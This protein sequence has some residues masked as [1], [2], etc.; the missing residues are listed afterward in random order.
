[1]VPYK[2]DKLSTT[3]I[4]TAQTSLTKA[5]PSSSSSLSS[6]TT[7]RPHLYQ[8]KTAP[9][10]SRLAPEDALTLSQ[11]RL[12][13]RGVEE[14]HRPVTANGSSI[15]NTGGLAARVTAATTTTS[16]DARRKREKA[17]LEGSGVGGGSG[18]RRRRVW[19]KLLWV[20]QSCK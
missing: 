12:A 14:Y 8:R 4:I 18:S 19:K 10:P 15:A 7:S 9:D 20:K 5:V 11:I 1:M 13:A 2:G 3:T 17:V 16:A 6:S